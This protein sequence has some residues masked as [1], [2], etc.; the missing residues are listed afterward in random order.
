MFKCEVV[1]LPVEQASGLLGLS[2]IITVD[3]DPPLFA[4]VISIEVVIQRLSPG[5]D[6][7]IGDSSIYMVGRANWS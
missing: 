4:R 7:T 5:C 1:E 3:D 6:K 2:P